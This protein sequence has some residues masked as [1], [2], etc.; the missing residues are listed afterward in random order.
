MLRI[1]KIFLILTLMALSACSVNPATGEKQFTA[2]MS[3]QQ[4]RAIG[5]QEH[6]KIIELFGEYRDPD[7]VNYVNRVGEQI[8]QNTEQP[9]M[10]FRFTVLDTPMV[11]AFALP[12]GYVYVS[13]GLAL[14]ANSEAELAAVLAHEIG[15][16]TAR[17]SAERYSHGVLTSLGATVLAAATESS[18]LSQAAGLGGNL[19][20]KSYSRGQEHQADELGVRYLHSSGYAPSAMASFLANLE[21][22]SAFEARLSGSGQPMPFNYFSTHPRTSDRIAEVRSIASRYPRNDGVID[23]GEYLKLIDGTVYG[24]SARHGFARGQS[25]YHPAMGFTFSVPR[26]FRIINQPTEVVAAGPDGAIIL[27]DAAQT[28]S[29]TDPL[30]YLTRIWMGG[31][32]LKMRESIMINGMNAATAAFNARVNGKPV[33]VRIVAVQWEPNRFFRFQMAIPRNAD[34]QFVDDLKRTTYSF[35]KMTGEEKESIKPYIMDIIKAGSGD[36]ASS[37]ARRMAFENLK[38]ERFRVLNAMKPGE[39]VVTGEIYKIVSR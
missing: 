21:Q 19:Y 36:T 22:Y 28:S 25:F 31:E 23:R 27:F 13:R 16:I 30:T 10:N 8:A 35:R 39:K 12:G 18:T 26:G 29:A 32:E 1:G 34:A 4:E 9:D 24:D 37:L 33:T 2:F 17:H 3:P 20:I 11:N 15:H 38:E 14:Q 5:A 6:A 7:L